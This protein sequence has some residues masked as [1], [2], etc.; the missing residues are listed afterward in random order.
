MKMLLKQNARGIRPLRFFP[1]FVWISLFLFSLFLPMHKVTVTSGLASENTVTLTAFEYYSVNV[2]A[3]KGQVLSGDWDVSPA[4]VI[5]PPFLVFI[6]SAEHFTLWSTSNNLTQAINR[7]PSKE[8]LYLYDPL[9]RTDDI[10]FDNYRSDLIQVKVP[11]DNSWHL[12]FYAGATAFPLTF[13]WHL[14]VFEGA[15]V[16]AVMWSLGAILLVAIVVTFVIYQ[17]KE[18]KKSFEEEFERIKQE[19]N[20]KFINLLELSEDE[21]SQHP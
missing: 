13:H 16:N 3:K 4:D 20:N 12:V 14:D 5:T 6:L 7:I 10:P 15:V 11:T 19:E 18:Q 21:D 1:Q 9:F 8:L 2:T 17:R